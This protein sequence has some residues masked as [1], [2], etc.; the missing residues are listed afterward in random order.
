MEYKKPRKPVR[1]EK[2][3]MSA[4]GIN[5]NKYL[6][7][8]ETDFYLIIVEKD[9]NKKKRIDKFRRERRKSYV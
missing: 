9:T 5:A 1:W 6:V 8:G 7:A 4:N 2:E 3:C